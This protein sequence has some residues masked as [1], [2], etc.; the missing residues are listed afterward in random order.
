MDEPERD[1]QRYDAEMHDTIRSL[2]A[3]VEQLKAQ[4]A[5]EKR[6]LAAAE[7]QLAALRDIIR[8]A[9]GEEGE[10]PPSQDGSTRGYWWRTEMRQRFR[11]ALSAP[12]QHAGEETC[13]HC[14]PEHTEAPCECKCHKAQAG[15]AGA[16]D[17]QSSEARRQ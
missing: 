12:T 4:L 16:F 9:L 5:D 8:W 10:F 13:E 6:Q 7:A 15:T 14:T 3:E 2:R 1:A 17:F 11:A